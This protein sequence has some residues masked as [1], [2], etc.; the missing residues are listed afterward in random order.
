MFAT[1]HFVFLHLPKTAGIFVESVCDEELRMPIL[2]TRRHAPFSELPERFKS[3]PTIGIRRDP[4]DWYA[5]LY[6]FA[7]RAR[8]EATSEIVALA[9]E[10]YAL[11]F[12]ATLERML[13][14]D[15]KLIRAYELR[16]RELGGRVADF[17]CM[18][19]SS[20]RR[21]RDAG[22]GL[23]T[24]LSREIF[25]EKLDVEWSMERLRPQMFAFLSPMCPDRKRF[26][27]AMA[28]RPRNVSGKPDLSLIYSP[29]SA[30]LV[31]RSDALLITRGG[32]LPPLCQPKTAGCLI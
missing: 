15:E 10:G 17:E 28:A 24:F 26:R 19:E 22:V 13:C 25:P 16:M 8:N 23:M 5:S 20:L 32:Y 21:Q 3:L 27:Q 4:W 30:D 7:K 29:F 12:E 18:N 6:Y 1:E 9:S 14:P 31:A 11:G 2:H